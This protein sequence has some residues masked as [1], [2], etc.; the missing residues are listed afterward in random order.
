MKKAIATFLAGF[1][2]LVL[3][4]GCNSAQTYQDGIYRAEFA[5]YDSR[6]YKDFIE[7]TVRDGTV[8]SI[9]YD[10][11]N[12]EGSFKSRDEKYLRDM[13]T[14]QGTTPTRFS[15]DLINQYLETENID[16]V[17][18]IAGATYSSN[19]FV[20]LFQALE[21]KMV[22]GDTTPLVVENISEK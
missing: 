4:C 7:V 14:V 15:A 12:E 22:S 18:T 17:D 21:P 9:V 13:E 11:V 19:S 6:G 16:K 3:L 8:I 10:A 1:F 20:A 5:N 2:C